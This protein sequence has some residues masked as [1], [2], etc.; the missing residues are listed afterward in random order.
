M[1][2]EEKLNENIEAKA[3]LAYYMEELAYAVNTPDGQKILVE[4]RSVL[5][6]L[7]N[8]L[9][10]VSMQELSGPYYEF[11][12]DDLQKMKALRA[13]KE[14]LRGILTGLDGDLLLKESSKLKASIEVLKNGQS[15]EAAY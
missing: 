10:T 7:N 15:L 1:T 9:I 2:D 14:I 5:N 8:S 4:L 3:K 13:K 11:P 6:D 12:K